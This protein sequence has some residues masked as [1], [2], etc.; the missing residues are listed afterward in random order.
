MKSNKE[1]KIDTFKFIQN[2]NTI[3]HLLKKKLMHT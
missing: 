1:K 2:K 3:Q